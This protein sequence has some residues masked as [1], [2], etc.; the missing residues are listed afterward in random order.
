MQQTLCSPIP[1]MLPAMNNEWKPREIHSGR[2]HH[3]DSLRGIAA[4]GVAFQHSTAAFEFGKTKEYIYPLFGLSPVVFFFLLSGF[5]LSRSLDVEKGPTLSGVIGYCIRRIFRLCPAMLVSMLIS[6]LIAWLVLSSTDWSLFSGWL[7]ELVG[8]MQRHAA[9]AGYLGSVSFFHETCVF[10][11]PLWTIR[12]EFACSFLLPLL[13]LLLTRF[14]SA[15]L[16]VGAGL[17]WMLWRAGYHQIASYMFPFYLGYMIHRAAPHLDGIGEN[18]TKTVLFFA[19]LLWIFSIKQGFNAVTGSIILGVVLLVMVPCRWPFLHRLLESTP[20][21]FLG[22]ISYS[23]YLLHFPL[24]L[25]TCCLLAKSCGRFL[26][27]SQRPAAAMMLF[28]V[29]VA[30]TLIVGQVSERLV[31]APFNRV[32]RG[33]AKRLISGFRD[34]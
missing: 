1:P 17:A 14:P 26:A 21:K 6:A 8:I 34:G 32:G 13:I 2:L 10:N 7:R 16:P 22:R 19:F 4:L 23:F 24:M 12:E 5:V 27:S 30:A 18:T 9:D 11:P 25:L 28:V 3:L 33:L 20:L 15:V 31:E 29:S